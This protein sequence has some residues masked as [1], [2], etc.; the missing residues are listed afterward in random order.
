[1]KSIEKKKNT[2]FWK[3][4]DDLISMA[5][6]QILPNRIMFVTWCRFL[7]YNYECFIAALKSSKFH[8]QDMV[9]TIYINYFN[10]KFYFTYNIVIN[11]YI[12]GLYICFFHN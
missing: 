12:Q 7:I 3:L 5:Y 1:M 11:N 9:A 4:N 6:V 10:G 2:T 8:I